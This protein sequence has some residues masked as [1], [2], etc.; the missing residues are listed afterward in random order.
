MSEFFKRPTRFYKISC[1]SH[2]LLLFL[3][4]THST[5]NYNGLL[6]VPGHVIMHGLVPRS[7]YLL[8]PSDYNCFSLNISSTYIL[9]YFRSLLKGHPYKKVVFRPLFINFNAATLGRHMTFP[10]LIIPLLTPCHHCSNYIFHL[11]FITPD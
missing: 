10:Y 5:L 9:T 7:F 1:L 6:V 2:L 8:L 3:S 11:S 4:Y